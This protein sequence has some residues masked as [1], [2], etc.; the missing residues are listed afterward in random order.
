MKKISV[1]C[2]CAGLL[3]FSA[4]KDI[5]TS[6]LKENQGTFILNSGSDNSTISYYNFENESCQN[7][8]FQKNNGG[9]SI[10]KNVRSMAIRR[11]T[12]YPDG[13]GY[14]VVDG[15]IEV[16]DMK[17]FKSIKQIDGISNPGDIILVSETRGY[18][19]SGN[20]TGDDSDVIIELDLVNDTKGDSYKVG[21][22]PVKMV[23]SGKYLYVANKGT[24]AVADNRIMVIDL[25]QGTVSVDT[26]EVA[27]API[28]LGVDK[29]GHV[30]AYC[31]GT[32][33]NNDQALVKLEKV[34]NADNGRL[35]H[36]TVSLPFSER[37]SQGNHCL[38]MSKF[39]G[40]LFY[41][42]GETYRMNVSEKEPVARKCITGDYAGTTF[43][44]IDVDPRT[45]RF[46]AL[47]GDASG[48]M[49]EYTIKA[50]VLDFKAE[51]PVGVNPISTAYFY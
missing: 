21:N 14:V 46:N 22:A 41:V 23:T 12:A 25:S 33:T 38:T 34:F 31:N 5:D 50:N 29:F 24:E 26:V 18:V 27:A 15:H 13:K 16:I 45:G 1:L 42:H 36:N 32:G 39:G 30:W 51:Y 40:E 43:S 11:G 44:S 20:G 47:T 9:Q 37:K 35:E 3:S 2:L 10:G 48:K 8:Y 19:T 7:D 6:T 28:D 4:C 17:T 49:V